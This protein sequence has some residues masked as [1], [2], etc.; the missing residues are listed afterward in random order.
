MIVA[1]I[2][3]ARAVHVLANL[4]S[5][6]SNPVGV[7]EIW[8]GGLSSFGGLALALPV[9]FVSTRR[10]CPMLR[11]GPAADLVAPVLVAAWAVGRLLGPQFE[12][13]GGGKPTHAWYGMYYAGQVGKR[14]PV[15]IFQAIECFAIYAIAL[16]VERLVRRRG[17]PT[18]LVTSLVVGLWGL[19][20]F[21][22]EYFWL[23]HDNGTDAVE[24]TSIV[25]FAIGMVTAGWLMRR[26][27]RRSRAAHQRGHDA[28]STGPTADL[29][30]E[31]EGVAPAD[32]HEEATAR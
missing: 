15:P 32:P 23:T 29:L 14:I 3:G 28:V 4:S 27:R 8:K 22:D 10:R 17:G 1:A 20:R 25:L 19:S 12:Y 9:G 21:F 30:D 11:L 5:Y 18:G 16:A 13:A 6:R 26:H 2:V 24:I 31:D 7:V